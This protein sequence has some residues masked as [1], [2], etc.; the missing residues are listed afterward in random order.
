MC[1]N[2]AKGITIRFLEKTKAGNV[3]LKKTMQVLFFLCFFS[4]GSFGQVTIKGTVKDAE[5]QYLQGV[6]VTLKGTKINQLT[7]SVGDYTIRIP[8]SGGN[9]VFSYIGMK[10]QEIAISDRKVIDVILVTNVSV[11]SDVV[12]IGYGS[13]QSR[14]EVTGS[15]SK[16][17]NKVLENIPYANVASALQGTIAG[18]RVQNSSGQPGAAPNVVLRGTTSINSPDAATP[19]YI[20]DGVIRAD[21]NDVATEDIANIQ[22]LK[23]AAS[24]SIYGARGSNGVIIVTTKSG[25]PGKNRIDYNYALTISNNP[26]S[27]DLLSA[28]DF[29]YYARL[30][31]LANAMKNPGVKSLLAGSNGFGTGNDLTNKTLYTTQ[32]LTPANQY[33][34]TD[35][36]GWESMPDPVDSTKTLIFKNTDFQA[37]LYQRSISQNHSIS[38]SGGT[39]NATFNARVGYLSMDG[40]AKT[41]KYQ[42]LSLNLD[43]ELRLRENLKAFGRVMY[44]NSSNNAVPNEAFVWQRWVAT[45]PTSKYRFEDGTLASGPNFSLGNPDYYLNNLIRKNNSAITT[46]VLGSHWDILPGLSFDPQVSLYTINGDSRQFEKGF[47]SAYNQATRNASAAYNKQVQWQADAVFSY[48]KTFKNDHHIS[49]KAGYS[50]FSVENST[51]NAS[52]QG[53]AT[54]LIPTLNASALPTAVSSTIVQ[55]V[56]IGYFARINYD[57]KRRYL[58]SLNARYDGASNLGSEHQFGFFP[59]ISAGWNLNNEKFWKIFPENLFQLKLRASYGINGNQKAIGPYQAQGTYTPVVTYGGNSA[60]QNTVLANPSLQW[61]QSKTFDGGAD[62]GIFNHRVGI[63]FDVYRRV[64]DHLLAS[65]ALPF[66]TG[67]TSI[68]TNL[69]TLENKGIEIELRASILPSSS[70]LQWDISVNAA[71]VETKIL[72][73]PYNGTLNNRIGG[74]LVW[75]TQT[76][77]YQWKG[78]LQ[79]GGRLGDMYAYHKI[80]IF[81]SDAEAAAGPVDNIVP[82]VSKKKFGGD[83]NWEDVDKNGIIDSRDQVY[84]GNIYPV[85]T[86]GISTTLSYKGL[87]LY[88]RADFTT[89]TTIFNVPQQFFYTMASGNNNLTANVLKSWLK[90][91]DEKTSQF[92]RY[93]YADQ[94]VSANYIRGSSDN[95]ESGNFMNIREVTLSYTLPITLIQRAKITNLRV[96]V[97]GNNLSYITHYSG[98]NPEQGGADNGRY[99]MPANFIIGANITL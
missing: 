18:L 97:T 94:Q 35:G 69:A 77:S 58:L 93:Y 3:F 14:S 75:D 78:G 68:V 26:K 51:L 59:G 79:E 67:F 42:R 20:I 37:A 96:F 80:G 48:D 36:T 25:Q 44:S 87:S 83:V 40:I 62:I 53:A 76:G 71:K 4:L 6:T 99:P 15:I 16:L 9:L 34:L 41:T 89:G 81:G 56:L 12:V 88:A 82:G 73:L 8:R 95:Y 29:I 65:M 23:D 32:Y 66:S 54:D 10:S 92:P 22:V 47:L 57:Y 45:P 46:L 63:L 7:D 11:F 61:E 30:G 28:R 38:A 33:K 74:V 52:G 84:M 31:I 85:W 50:Y 13:S 27:Y 98:L 39:R 43:G 70:P 1:Q 17:D 86:G 91:G 90:P 19:L 24:T 5:G 21:M 2:F 55:Q 60:I 49:A 64:T 72:K